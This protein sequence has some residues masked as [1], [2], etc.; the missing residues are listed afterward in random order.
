MSESK[1]DFNDFISSSES[2]APQRLLGKIQHEI[3]RT[4]PGLLEVIVLL[5]GIHFLSSV[6]SLAACPQ[7]GVRLFFEG[8]G[9]D[10][11]FMHAGHEACFFLCGFFYLG[12]TFLLARWALPKDAWLVLKKSRFATVTALGLLSMG[13]LSIIGHTLSFELS[14]IWFFGAY[15]G[16]TL[17]FGGFNKRK[18][19]HTS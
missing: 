6:L 7:F 15:L 8:H 17:P 9:L 2:P 13:S 11:L 10:H 18:L 14:V 4:T 5:G 3:Q 19:V 16:A 12:L 1:N